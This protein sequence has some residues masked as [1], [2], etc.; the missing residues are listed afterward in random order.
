M[1]D[2][3]YVHLNPSPSL[4]SILDPLKLRRTAAMGTTMYNVNNNLVEAMPERLMG[5][6][7]SLLAV[8]CMDTIRN[9]ERPTAEQK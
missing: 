1:P 6:P 7:C 3:E 9:L 8:T 2:H 5:K 4:Y